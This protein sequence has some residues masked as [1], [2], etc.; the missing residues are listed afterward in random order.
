M[1]EGAAHDHLTHRHWGPRLI[2]FGGLA[3]RY[4]VKSPPPELKEHTGT[5]D[6]DVVI[7]VEIDV[8]EEGCTP[9][10]RRKAG[11]RDS[12]RATG[13]LR[14]GAEGGRRERHPGVLLPG[15]GGGHAGRPEA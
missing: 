12:R 14:V 13:K 2:L 6:L 9:S 8:A 7:G 4:L 5:T 11:M 1:R 10:S 15:R 3:P